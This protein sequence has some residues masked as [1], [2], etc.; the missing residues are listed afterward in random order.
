MLNQVQFAGNLTRD[1]DL[2]FAGKGTAICKFSAA[3]NRR[4]KSE[5]G[6]E[7][8]EVTFVDFTAFGKTGEA[9]AKYFKK[10]KPIIVVVRLKLDQWDDKASGQKRSKLGVVVESF[11]FMPDGSRDAKPATQAQPKAEPKAE[12]PPSA[13]EAFDEDSVPF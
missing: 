5:T 6:E 11:S 3:A 13:E 9:I 8:E 7:K 1:P 12:L 10:G 2:A 4:W